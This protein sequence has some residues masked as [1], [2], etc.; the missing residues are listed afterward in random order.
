MT[1]KITK[2]RKDTED[3]RHLKY[4]LGKRSSAERQPLKPT[5][6]RTGKNII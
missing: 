3:K 6:D 5:A 2:P 4:R 1:T